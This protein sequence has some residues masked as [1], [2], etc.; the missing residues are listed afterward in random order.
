MTLKDQLEQE[1]DKRHV[2]RDM[3]HPRRD[4]ENCVDDLVDS[5]PNWTSHVAS[6]SCIN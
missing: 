4:I 2:S 3:D 6:Q 1:I 5:Q